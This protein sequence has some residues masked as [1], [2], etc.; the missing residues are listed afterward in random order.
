T[1][2]VR[3]RNTTNRYVEIL[4]FQHFARFMT[5]TKDGSDFKNKVIKDKIEVSVVLDLDLDVVCVD[6]LNSS[7]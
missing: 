3:N 2:G 1:C 6:M 5:F 7:G 4:C